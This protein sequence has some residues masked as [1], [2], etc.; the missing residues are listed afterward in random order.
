MTLMSVFG[1]KTRVRNV[2]LLELINKL[3]I[4]ILTET[5][6]DNIDNIYVPDFNFLNKK[7]KEK[8]RGSGGVAVLISEE[9]SNKGCGKYILWRI[10]P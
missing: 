1:L 9:Q 2:E 4:I 8:R 10:I 6:L 3:Y 7:I 5:K